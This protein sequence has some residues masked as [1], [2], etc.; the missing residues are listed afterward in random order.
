MN[1]CVLG[2]FMTPVVPKVSSVVVGDLPVPDAAHDPA[3]LVVRGEAGPRHGPGLQGP[4]QG[5]EAGVMRV[6]L[7]G[8]GVEAGLGLL[9]EG[10]GRVAAVE[11]NE[12]VRVLPVVVVPVEEG[13]GAAAGELQR[14]H[15]DRAHDVHLAGG[16]EAARRSSCS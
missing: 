10:E 9:H 15:R 13:R 8:H 6:A 16:G 11:E 1:F 5:A 3:L 4:V 7:D 12:L 14:V 2:I